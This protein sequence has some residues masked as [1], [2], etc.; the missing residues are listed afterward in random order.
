MD[1]YVKEII[2]DLDVL[3]EWCTEID[4]IKE[5]KESQEIIKSLKATMRANDLVSLSAPQ[6]GYPRRIICIK[7]GKDDYRTMINP[8]VENVSKIQFTREKCSSIS[9]K[10]YILP[11]F[12]TT[13]LIYTTPLGK[14][15]SR[16]ILGKSA[17]VIQH[18]VDHLNGIKISDY[19]LEI[20]EL[21]DQ[22]TDDERAEVLK[23]YAEALDVRQKNL[24]KEIDDNKEL[25]D[26]DDAARFI[27]SVKSG[28][29]I[30]EIDNLKD[31]NSSK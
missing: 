25:K 20:D 18:C 16:K 8:M 21:W 12:T 22:A 27:N 24:Q 2:T 29:T 19:G 26:I 31:E 11:R 13:T 30:L 1:K 17:F 5:G 28:E 7:F 6:I 23:A 9:D 10:E 3:S 15:E 4:P 14:I